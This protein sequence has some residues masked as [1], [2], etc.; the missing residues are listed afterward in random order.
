LLSVEDSDVDSVVVEDDDE[1][2][3]DSEDDVDTWVVS[4]LDADLPAEGSTCW[5]DAL[6][7]AFS[8]P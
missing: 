4:E 1:V 6:A 5:M 8:S 2:E 7:A 3:V